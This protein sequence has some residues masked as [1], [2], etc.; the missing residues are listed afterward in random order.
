MKFTVVMSVYNDE[1]PEF[2]YYSLE[3]LAGQSLAADEVV[4]VE[5][6]RIGSEL[7]DTI[8]RF[9]ETL[10][11]RSVR[12]DTNRGLAEALNQGLTHCSH[13]IVARM[14]TDD[15]CLPSRFEKQAARLA[16]EKDIDVLGT[17]AVEIDETGK[18]GMLRKKPLTHKNIIKNLW[19]NPF[20][21]SSVMFK[22]TKV[23]EAGGYNPSLQRRQDYELWFRLARHG[24]KFSNIAEPL[25]LYRFAPSSHQKQSVKLAWQQ[26][27]IGYSGACM[28][29]MAWWKKAACFEP[30]L[31]SMLPLKIQHM[32]Y[33]ALRKII[34]SEKQML[35]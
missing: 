20:I 13:E 15:V 7:A 34:L 2:L 19:S 11:I 21:H 32:A 4:L 17:L 18:Q 23:L 22:K 6:G 27:V 31:R 25:L 3:S 12:L 5:D 10:N 8:E 28:L 26:A 24:L 1:K 33:T 30:F 29:N 16:S 9:R 35:S 14:D